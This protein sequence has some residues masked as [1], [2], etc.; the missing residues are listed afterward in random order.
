MREM[1]GLTHAALAE[2]TDLQPESISRLER[3]QRALSLGNLAVIAGV[4]QV[5][6]GD[7]LDEARGP[8]GVALTSDEVE[9][10][11]TY[12]EMPA[13]RRE[14]ARRLMREMVR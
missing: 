9:L 11:Q 1:H 10:L 2:A 4:F 13:E 5:P 14:L 8:P 3:G 6:L 7:L 12:R